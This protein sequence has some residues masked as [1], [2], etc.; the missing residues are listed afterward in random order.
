M[1]KPA[2]YLDPFDKFTTRAA[3]VPEFALSI[4]KAAR[5]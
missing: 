5:S 3:E 4:A 2:A 1:G